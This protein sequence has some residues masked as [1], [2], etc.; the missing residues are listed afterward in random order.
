MHRSSI[1]ILKEEEIFVF[2]IGMFYNILTIKHL[3]INTKITRHKFTFNVFV[4]SIICLYTSSF[5][6]SMFFSN[7]RRMSKIFQALGKATF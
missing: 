6:F 1:I 3:R 5:V 7:D 2:S 4:V